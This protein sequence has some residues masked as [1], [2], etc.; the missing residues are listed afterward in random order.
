MKTVR[1]VLYLHHGGGLGGAPLSLLELA[2]GLKQLGYCPEIV[3]TGFGPVLDLAKSS[4]IRVDVVRLP[5]A[6]SYG[7][8]VPLRVRM[9]LRWMVSSRLTMQRSLQLIKE[10]QP[11]LVHLNSSVLLPVARAA[12]KLDIPLVWHIREVPGSNRQL[13]NWQGRQIVRLADAVIATSGFVRS[14]L[15]ASD[16]VHVIHNAVRVAVFQVGNSKRKSERAKLGISLDAPVVAILGNVQQAKGHFFLLEA[17]VRV[18]RKVPN[19]KFIV[20][21]AGAGPFYR[22]SWKGRV[23]RAL[24]L[25]LD[26]RERLRRA[27]REAGLEDHYLFLDFQEDVAGILAVADLLVFPSLAPEGFGRPL[28]EAMAAGLP[29]VATR[30][31]PTSEIVGPEAARLVE[32]GDVE[33]LAEEIVGLLQN[34]ARASEMGEKGAVRAHNFFSLD[35]HLQ[36]IDGIYRKVLKAG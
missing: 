9:V 35:L 11:E 10:R 25:P 8:H 23:K 7:M 3:F 29:I 31:G 32:P 21:A 2:R 30:V 27:V 16:R 20:A 17:S 36:K 34:P 6:F 26:N 1:R 33:G 28:I 13:R 14:A 5:A 19:V 4:G 24:H 22:Q 15:P 18:V 12:R